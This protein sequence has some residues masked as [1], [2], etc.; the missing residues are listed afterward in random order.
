MWKKSLAER[1][2]WN[3]TVNIQGGLGHNIS[4]DLYNEHLNL[5]FKRKPSHNTNFMQYF[6][7]SF[8]DKL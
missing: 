1:I 3:R 7:L 2:T 5:D 8:R 4:T 6:K